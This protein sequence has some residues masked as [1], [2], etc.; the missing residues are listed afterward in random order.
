M[1]LQNC[2]GMCL[3]EDDAPQLDVN[4][5]CVSSCCGSII[6]EEE[7]E[8]EEV[9]KEEEEEEKHKSIRDDAHTGGKRETKADILQPIPPRR[10]S[11]I[12]SV[13]KCC[14]CFS[15]EDETVVAATRDVHFTSNCP[16]A[17]SHS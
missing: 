12:K 1:A 16:E 17:L 8:E 2:L 9:D 15:K 13:G 10:L 5:K 6:E 4:V 11:F 3:K 14:K 7:E